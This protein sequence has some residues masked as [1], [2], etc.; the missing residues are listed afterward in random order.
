MLGSC[1]N[2]L[3][4]SDGSKSRSWVL[5]WAAYPATRRRRLPIP[6]VAWVTNVVAQR[7]FRDRIHSLLEVTPAGGFTASANSARLAV[8]PVAPNL[9]VPGG[10]QFDTA[11]L[12]AAARAHASGTT[13]ITNDFAGFVPGSLASFVWSGFRTN[14]RTTNLWAFWQL[15]PGWPNKPPILR[16]NTNSLMWGLRGLTAISQVCEGMGGFG[17][18]AL[19][20]LTRRHVYLRGHGM[21]PSGFSPDRV[22][23]RI[24][25]CTRDNKVIERKAQYVFIRSPEGPGTPDYSIV[26]LD[27]D[28]PASIQP[29]R[30]V[31]PVK[32]R[33]KYLFVPMDY[34]PEIM[35]LQGGF[36]SA[37]IPPWDIPIQGGDSGAPR[38]L[39]L[40][41]ELVFLEG[42]TTSPPSAAM[43]ADM[44]MLSLKAGLDPRKY[45]MQWVNLDSYPDF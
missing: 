22:G 43:Q 8:H 15:P 14:G 25:F 21:G 20:A 27:A 4:C 26:L 18:G 34:K 10:W 39:P 3:Y 24:W 35:T 23:K 6:P 42:I 11:W 1:Q 28:L 45:Q 7:T 29:M 44:D 32:V 17:Q 13:L 31:D 36:V 37:G 9:K 5:A 30:V 19:T 33:R 16:W 12:T 2:S 40:P 38:M 41:G